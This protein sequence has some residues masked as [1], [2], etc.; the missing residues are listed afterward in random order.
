MQALVSSSQ[1]SKRGSRRV[2]EL[3]GGAWTAVS[4]P[5]DLLL[6][7]GVALLELLPRSARLRMREG[8]LQ[9]ECFAQL[10]NPLELPLH[11]R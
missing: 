5:L 7:G 11:L 6:R 1:F 2:H 4:E 8:A 9:V 3:G 10:A